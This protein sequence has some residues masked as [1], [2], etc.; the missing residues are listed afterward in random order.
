LLT[1]EKMVLQASSWHELIDK[2]ALLILK[3]V[4]QELYEI[5]VRQLPKVIDFSLRQREGNSIQQQ[6]TSTYKLIDR[7]VQYVPA[8]P[9][10]PGT[11]PG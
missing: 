3:A 1:P 5:G 10:D 4:T 2:K 11:L 9:C 8:I 6:A 7:Q